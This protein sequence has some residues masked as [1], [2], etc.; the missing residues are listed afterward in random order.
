MT[1][2][3][4]ELAVTDAVKARQN[5]A[6]S[7]TVEPGD[8]Y[9]PKEVVYADYDAPVERAWNVDVTAFDWNCSKHITQ[10]FTEADIMPSIGKLITRI[11][12]LEAQL[13][14]AAYSR[15]K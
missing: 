1:A 7:R 6:G 12:G 13:E 4:A 5:Q 2:R 3:C 11:C 9:F 14:L 15:S 8:P 10:R